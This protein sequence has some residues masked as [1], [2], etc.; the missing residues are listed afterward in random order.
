LF[1]FMLN[2]SMLAYNDEDYLFDSSIT[3][4]E[5]YNPQRT[6]VL[7][8]LRSFR[9]GKKLCFSPCLYFFYIL[10]LYSD[11]KPLVNFSSYTYIA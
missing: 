4:A 10:I 9:G 5:K 8:H 3:R 7:Q 11:T 1:K 6:K 2:F